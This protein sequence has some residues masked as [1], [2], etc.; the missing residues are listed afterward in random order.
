[1]KNIHV[2]INLIL[3]IFLSIDV[4]GEESN[5]NIEDLHNTVW[6]CTS[7]ECL[8]WG[9][10][11]GTQYV[12]MHFFVN[13]HYRSPICTLSY[14]YCHADP[15]KSTAEHWNVQGMLN[16]HTSKVEISVGKGERNPYIPIEI[17]GNQLILKNSKVW[18]E[19]PDFIFIKI[20]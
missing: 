8:K 12:E 10:P 20:R 9:A 3:S 1:M 11:E 19:K 6:R 2:I 15:F 14:V 13:K 17:R 18:K 16:M 5:I 4:Y 7:K